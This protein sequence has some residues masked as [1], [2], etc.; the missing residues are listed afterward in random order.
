MKSSL[1]ILALL[2]ADTCRSHTS[3]PN[4]MITQVLK[5]T[6]HL[7]AHSPAHKDRN[8]LHAEPLRTDQ[9]H[10][11]SLQSPPEVSE[12]GPTNVNKDS[13]W[14][15]FSF[16]ST[17]M[18]MGFSSS[19]ASDTNSS[20]PQPMVALE[21]SNIEAKPSSLASKK[22]SR[23]TQVEDVS[24][25]PVQTPIGDINIKLGLWDAMSHFWEAHC[26]GKRNTN[27]LLPSPDLGLWP[28]DYPENEVLST[29]DA[30]RRLIKDIIL[31][32]DKQPWTPRKYTETKEALEDEEYG[33]KAG[34]VAMAQG[35]RLEGLKPLNWKSLDGEIRE[36]LM[37]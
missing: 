32:D 4:P 25:I 20:T 24:D 33:G 28:H 29:N 6:Q 17:L 26:A 7:R 14:W 30:V 2:I 31:L 23:S 15:P 10:L 22:F 27:P 16:G 18:S 19:N 35:W 21:Q 36:W 12:P 37:P 13:K 34:L 5:A 11:N 3:H 9:E 8:E 1:S